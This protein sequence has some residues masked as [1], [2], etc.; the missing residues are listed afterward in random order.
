LPKI[1]LTEGAFGQGPAAADLAAFHLPDPAR[2]G[3]VLLVPLREVAEM[4]MVGSDNT[5]RVKNAIRGGAVGLLSLGPVGIAA[6]MRAAG[7]APATIFTVRL[8]DGRTFTAR[9][10]AADFADIHA[11][12]VEARASAGSH[13]A[14][15]V[16]AKYLASAPVEPRPTQ[17]APPDVAP[18]P[19][20]PEP[21]SSQSPSPSPRPF[22]RRV[23]RDG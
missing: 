21:P 10:T 8:E 7:K 20:S 6:G 4:T 1:T 3:G 12:Q 9:A 18:Q 13:P 19:K 14:D 17:P 16:I 22:G 2:R 23:P 5:D 11:A 15:A